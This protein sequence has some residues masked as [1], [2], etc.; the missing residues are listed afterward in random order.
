MPDTKEKEELELSIVMPCL[1]EEETVHICV[2]KAQTFLRENGISGEVVV[3]DNGSTDNSVALAKKAGARVVFAKQRGYGAALMKGISSAR[4]KYVIMGD[5][6][7]SYDFLNLMPFVEKLREGF[8]LVMGNRF[9]SKMVKGAMPFLHRYLGNPVLSF[10]GRI[11]Y[12]NKIGDFHCGL[13]G[14]TKEAFR[15]MDLRTTG[16]EFASEMIVKT[17]IYAM[18]VTEVPT[19]LSPD[20]RTGKGHL[21]TWTD[22]WRHLRF[23]LLYS[24]RWLFLYPAL[25]I[26]LGGFGFMI[27][28]FISSDARINIHTLLFAVAGILIG[29][30]TTAFAIFTKTFAVHERL[31]P[32]NPTIEKIYDLMTLERGLMLGSFFIITGL[33]IAGYLVIFWVDTNFFTDADITDTMRIAIASFTFLVLGFQIIF[34]FFFYNYLKMQTR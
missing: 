2:W 8:H 12:S 15:K 6:D 22:G 14:F 30:Q 25:M 24:P 27:Y 28:T 17:T 34:S 13:R 5:S 1:N 33:G 32:I 4:G 26:M 3:S 20:G 31:I 10:L 9:K 18:K 16:M 7:D 29:F 11:F 23:L 21:R 19:Q